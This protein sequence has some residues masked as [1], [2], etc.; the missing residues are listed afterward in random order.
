MITPEIGEAAAGKDHV[1]AA[2]RELLSDGNAWTVRALLDT[3]IAKGL[4][5][6][7]TNAKYIYNAIVN[8]I[9]RQRLRGERPEF[10]R[11]PDGTFRINAPRDPFVGHSD[12]TEPNPELEKFV[13]DL[14]NA[15]QNKEG[16]AGGDSNGEVGTRFEEMAAAAFARLG[17]TSQRRGG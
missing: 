5:P 10:V 2:M 13:A 7:S 4:V 9:G 6:K 12:K 17:F 8:F 11:L 3:S 14:A 1:L 16:A 15:A